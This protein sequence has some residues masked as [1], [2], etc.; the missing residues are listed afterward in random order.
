MD[1]LK[2]AKANI[3]GHSLGSFVAQKFAEDFPDRVKKIVLVASSGSA[4]VPAQ[5]GGWLATEIGKLTEA[6][7]PDSEFMTAWFG[8]SKPE[9]EEF[10]KYEKIE[11]SKVPLQVW[12]GIL[13]E[14]QTNE[15]G[16]QLHKIKAPVLLV[17]GLH[18]EIFDKESQ[19][20]LRENIRNVKYVEYESGGHNI[21]WEL[22]KEFAHE[23]NIFLQEK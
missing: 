20:N 17:Y 14:A 4:S 21:P 8:A 19:N 7:K 5:N 13:A 6:P 16:R 18:D 1:S 3:V 2:I 22:P 11:S 9:N 12:K 15:F 10:I 23:V